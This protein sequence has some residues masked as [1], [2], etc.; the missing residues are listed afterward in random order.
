MATM[1]TR[2]AIA[3]GCAVFLLLALTASNGFVRD[4]GFYFFAARQYNAWNFDFSDAGLVKTFGYNHEH[5]GFAKIL[6]GWTWSLTG[7]GATGFRLGAI[8]LTAIGAAFTFLFGAKL[9]DTPTGLC[10]VIMYFAAPHVFYHAHLACFDAPVT[11]LI[12]A[13]TYAF[14]RSTESKRWIAPACIF[15][16]LAL[17]TKHNAVFTLGGFVIASALMKRAPL[18]LVLMPIAGLVIF[19]VFYPYGWHHPLQRIGAYYAY[20]AHHEHYP[21]DFFGTLYTKPPFPIGYAFRMTALTVPLVTLVLGCI[22]LV[23]VA[24]R[25]WGPVLLLLGALIPPLVISFPTVPIFGGTKHWMPMMPFFCIAAA[26]VLVE[27]ARSNRTALALSALALALPIADT[28]RT[29]PHGQTYFNELVLGHQGAAY[30]GLPRT[31]WGG[32]GRAMLDTLNRKAEEGAKVFTHRMNVGDWRQYR[33]DGLVR[34]DLVQVKTPA[35]ADWGLMY[36]QREHQEVEYLYWQR[37]GVLVDTLMFDGVP[38]VSLYALPKVA[39]P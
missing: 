16:G 27:I 26:S 25:E 3:V 6:M 28:I 12:V 35:E 21:V 22:G 7:L 29:H 18:S 17:A 39:A 11:G 13:S 15:W 4:E 9:R 19:Y 36:H 8:L 10:A 24:K 2:I 34:K 14:W 32:D 23:R 31:F 5:P 38:L 37:G 1:N 20:H 30:A 33:D